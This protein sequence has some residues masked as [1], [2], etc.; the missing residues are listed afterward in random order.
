MA[1]AQTIATLTVS[2]E[3][4]SPHLSV[5]EV[6]NYFLK[7]EFEPLLSI[8]VVDDG[9]PVGVVSRYQ[10]MN[11]FLHRYGRELHGRKPIAHMM[12]ARPLVVSADQSMED[13]SQYITSNIR[14]P[15]TE[16]FV[17]V[18]DGVYLGV[19][20]VLDLL[21]A[22]EGQLLR[23]TE[24]LSSAYR[25]LKASQAHL[26]QSEKMASLGQ[27]VAGVAHEINTPL[28]YV[29]NN[30]DL[31]LERQREQSGMLAA[32][33]QLLELMDAPQTDEALLMSLLGEVRE[34]GGQIGDDPVEET[35]ALFADTFYGIDQISE[36]V[37]GLKNFSR[38]DQAM[39]DN[40]NIN[41]CIDT[42]LKIAHNALK[43]KVTV[44]KQYGELPPVRCMPSKLNQVFLNL[45]TNAAQA[46]ETEGKLLLK[47]YTE[48][49]HLHVVVEDTGK[50][51]PDDV[52]PRIFD[53]F[54][55]TKP[56]GHGTGLGLAI[57]YQIIK[58]HGGIIR[59]A[60]KAGVGTRFVI[61]LPLQQPVA[62]P[63]AAAG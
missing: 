57:S 12:N 23:R 25:E 16:D 53:P 52:L 4:V 7:P 55:T 14:F 59:V 10:I 56:V 38:V 2:V 11:I 18:R 42:T 28:G 37:S 62:Q 21:K 36:L 63:L 22:M 43:H 51:I 5:E 6:G 8:P 49:G 26:V 31:F 27:M 47:T 32:Y 19:G 54:F 46:I 1:H 29:R 40:V 3:P 9:E 30:V 34:L 15:I 17:I 60:S 33:R 44:I 58:E 41:D 13:A 35:E 45:V 39:A 61:R 50:G 48:D 24:E 20:I